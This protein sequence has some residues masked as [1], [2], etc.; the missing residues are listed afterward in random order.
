MSNKVD[1]YTKK[2][3][4][5]ISVVSPYFFGKPHGSQNS[6]VVRQIHIPFDEV[7][8]MLC[9]QSPMQVQVVL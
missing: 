9:G 8:A 2:E 6:L 5:I 4:L 7:D 1:A 3:G